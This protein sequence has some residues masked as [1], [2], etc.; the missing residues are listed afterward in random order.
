MNIVFSILHYQDSSVT[1][2]CVDSILRLGIPKGVRRQIVIVDNCS[3]NGSGSYL[4]SLYKDLE[5]VKVLLNKSNEGFAKGNN[6][7]YSYAAKELKADAIIVMNNDIIIEQNDFIV[8]LERLISGNPG[9]AVFAPDII[10]KKGQHQNPYRKER[11]TVLKT[12]QLWLISLTYYVLLHLPLINWLFVFV[13]GI[14]DKIIALKKSSDPVIVK[15][16]DIVPH[17]AAVIYSS[18][19]INSEDSAF[20]NRTF[21]YAE[22]D[23][24]VEELN[25]KGLHTLYVPELRIMHLEDVA[26]ESIAS[27]SIKKKLFMS[28]HKVYST[29]ILL[30]ERIKNR[31]G[32]R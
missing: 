20:D 15:F 21:L 9:I 32:K 25:K 29:T 6:L 17:G 3:P 19:F 31:Y 23:L 11:L 24:L 7:G 18:L 1:T 28:K 27:T 8:E 30:K 5:D 22:E 4:E 26:T 14:K 10:N 13:L 16:Y 2:Q 12:A